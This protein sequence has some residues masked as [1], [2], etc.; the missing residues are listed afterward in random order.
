MFIGVLAYSTVTYQYWLKL[1][2]IIAVLFAIGRV[3]FF[4]GYALRPSWREAGFI[5]TFVPIVGL[6]GL[7]T[8][9]FWFA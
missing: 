8:Y 6:Y 1:I 9:M 7:T 2:P 3:L 4:I 5:M